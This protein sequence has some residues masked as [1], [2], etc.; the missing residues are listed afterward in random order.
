MAELTNRTDVKTYLGLSGTS[1]DDLLDD[2]LE[3]AEDT[4][5]RICGKGTGLFASAARTEKFPGAF[6]EIIY[7]T[8]RPVTAVTSVKVYTSSSNYTTVDST[9]Y[10]IND[11]GTAV[12]LAGDVDDIAWDIGDPAPPVSRLWRRY[13]ARQVKAYPYTELVYTGG[14]GTIPDDL[15]GHAKWY[16]G[17]LFMNRRTNSAMQSESL[18]DYSYTR[19]SGGNTEMNELRE[20]LRDYI[21]QM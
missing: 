6:Q 7:V 4:I 20:R 13:A 21:V 19:A 3:Q 14:Y 16:T 12:M 9:W 18:G 8:H 5:R 2:L 11:E 10:R 17:Q 15:A 1:Y